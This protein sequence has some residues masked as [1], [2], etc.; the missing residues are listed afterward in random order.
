MLEPYLCFFYLRC[1]Q[2]LD[3]WQYA[4]DMMQA[5]SNSIKTNLDETWTRQSWLILR[6]LGKWRYMNMI[7]M[8]IRNVKMKKFIPKGTVGYSKSFRDW[9]SPFS[10]WTSSA[11]LAFTPTYQSCCLSYLTRLTWHK[12]GHHSGHWWFLDC[13]SSLTRKTNPLLVINHHLK[14]P[15][16]H[17]HQLKFQESGWP[18]SFTIP[19]NCSSNASK[20]ALLMEVQSRL[21]IAQTS[22]EHDDVCGAR[23]CGPWHCDREVCQE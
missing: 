14:F 19:S 3:V 17:S 11:W 7:E 21:C 22:R 9:R 5:K 2:F 1:L 12:L 20:N 6:A 15:E 10:S 4:F 8:W 16:S 13:M 23:F 18:N